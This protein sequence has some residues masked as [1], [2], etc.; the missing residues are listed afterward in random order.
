MMDFR[1]TKPESIL[2]GITKHVA[3]IRPDDS[4]E[5]H[6]ELPATKAPDRFKML[7]LQVELYDQEGKPGY[8]AYMGEEWPVPKVVA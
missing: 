2:K 4:V 6:E 8:R 7:C 5:I 3:L 1:V